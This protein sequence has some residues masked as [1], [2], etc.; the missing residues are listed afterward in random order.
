[1]EVFGWLRGM[2]ATNLGPV[3]QA[4][5]LMWATVKQPV[6]LAI[7]IENHDGSSLHGH[8]LSSPRRDFGS[9][10]ND[11]RG[12]GNIMPLLNTAQEVLRSVEAIKPGRI[13]IEKCRPLLRCYLEG[14]NILWIVVIPM[15]VV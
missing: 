11:K 8:E 12:H 14:E 6:E 2:K 15:R 3:C 9:F 5:S 7:E 1:M 13:S 4:A 10:T